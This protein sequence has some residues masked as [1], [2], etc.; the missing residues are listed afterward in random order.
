[1]GTL[2]DLSNIAAGLILG[3][4]ALGKID[5]LGEKLEIVVSWLNPY[6]VVFGTI[7]LILGLYFLFQPGYLVHDI[8]GI[9]V[10]LLLHSDRLKQ[11]PAVGGLLVKASGFL[12]PFEVV[13]GI[14]AVVLG[15]LGLFDIS[16]FA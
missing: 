3:I 5:S 13:I 10:G 2:F 4:S 9:A 6:K 8:T 15:I 14:I 12:S 16:L 7:S 11:I 1:M